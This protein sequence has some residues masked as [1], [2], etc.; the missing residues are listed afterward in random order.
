[1]AIGLWNLIEKTDNS[2]ELSRLACIIKGIIWISLTVSLLV[3]RGKWI[4]ILNSIWWTTSSVLVSALN[5]DILFKGH[6]AFETFDIII[7]LVHF[8]LLLCAFKNLSYL[9]TNSVQEY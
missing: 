9:G 1:L 5:I 7:W 6:D 3:Q 8:L 4:K 2:K